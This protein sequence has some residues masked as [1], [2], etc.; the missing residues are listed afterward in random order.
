VLIRYRREGAPRRGSG[1]RIGK[2]FVLTADHCADGTDHTVIVAGEQHRATVKVRSNTSA[3]DLAVL[4]ASGLPDL[5]PMRCADINRDQAAIVTG[6]TALGFPIWKGSA[7][8]PLLAQASGYV[9]TAEDA[10]PSGRGVQRLS[11]KIDDPEAKLVP[12]PRGGLDAPGSVW[13]GMSGSALLVDNCLVGV[14]RSHTASEGE[15]SLTATPLSAI[16]SLGPELAGQ[17]WAALSLPD[18]PML[19]PVRTSAIRQVPLDPALG[20]LLERQRQWCSRQDIAFHTPAML[21]VLLDI[22][23]GAAARA[24]DAVGPGRANAVR[25]MLRDHLANEAA[26]SR[27][28]AFDWIDREDVRH[29]AELAD[30]DQAAVIGQRHL[31]LGVLGAETTTIRSLREWLGVGAFDRLVEAAWHADD[32]PVEPPTTPGNPFTRR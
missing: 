1:L 28:L 12:L 32:T 14:I 29:A 2:K 10:D 15:R 19:A 23:D 31:L 17:F 20:Q 24:F 11:F 5:E 26:G 3:V 30:A 4:D 25:T 27:F 21:R 6:C 9:P 8:R 7:D 13:A 18:P 16:G 22:P